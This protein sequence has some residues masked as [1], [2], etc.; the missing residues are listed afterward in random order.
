MLNEPK[1]P[2]STDELTATGADQG[3]LAGGIDRCEG[4]TIC[5]WVA[6]SKR[7]HKRVQLELL[8]DGEQ[9]AS[10]VADHFRADVEAA[11]I[12]D[13]RYGFEITVPAKYCD[14][15]PHALVLREAHTGR[16]IRGSPIEFSATPAPAPS[17]IG[18]QLP[19]G[20]AP[21]LPAVGKSIDG[22]VDDDEATEVVGWASRH[23]GSQASVEVELRVDGVPS[24]RAIADLQRGDLAGVGRGD[25]RYG[26]RLRLPSSVFDDKPHRI[27]VREVSTQEI[28]AQGTRIICKNACDR[29]AGSD[30]D[31]RKRWAL[32][33]DALKFCEAS[34]DADLGANVQNTLLKMR[35]WLRTQPQSRSRRRVQSQLNR[36][37]ALRCRLVM[38]G[39][40][41]AGRIGGTVVDN[42]ES[43]GPLELQLIEGD[44][45]GTDTEAPLVA[46]TEA[47]GSF[48]F[49]LPDHLLDDDVHRFQ[50]RPK[51]HGGILG[52]WSF[53][54]SSDA[55]RDRRVAVR[56]VD[57]VWDSVPAALASRTEDEAEAP[58]TALELARLTLQD[59]LDSDLQD[60]AGTESI[61]KLRCDVGDQLIEA[62]DFPGAMDE[63]EEAARIQAD[64][65]MGL[66]GNAAG[67][68]R[69]DRRP[70]GHRHWEP[71]PANRARRTSLQD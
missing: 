27:E 31:L 63:F 37:T 55:L 14:E 28:L 9:V 53:L 51:T 39:L 67:F 60:T 17:T 40:V 46:R 34:A 7:Y 35:E 5:G 68:A 65:A 52:P 2:Q 59:A 10:A 70:R 8:I 19:A 64:S 49:S 6:D 44:G 15:A 62:G 33:E 54:L 48:T 47:D 13:G 71:V 69:L 21:A 3:I 12:G 57:P 24:T 1:A 38:R 32:A 41:D 45:V 26:F 30:V 4:T 42:W 20:A 50:L 66:A 18:E 22:F 43:N 16:A 29:W 11:G 58:L 36:L 56:A 25:G 61:A 23:E